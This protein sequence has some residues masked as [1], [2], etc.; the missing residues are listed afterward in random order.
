MEPLDLEFENLESYRSGALFEVIG[1]ICI[2]D[3]FLSIRTDHAYRGVEDT[4][5]EGVASCWI[6]ATLWARLL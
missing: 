5:L 2:Q 3:C 4:Y 1:Q 6:G